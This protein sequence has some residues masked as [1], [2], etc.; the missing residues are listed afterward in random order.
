[1]ITLIIHL[2]FY[3]YIYI[4]IFILLY[5]SKEKI[6][7]LVSRL[8]STLFPYKN[9]VFRELLLRAATIATIA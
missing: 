9:T 5:L 4:T 1:M 8:K 7:F 2:S 6:F 3:Y